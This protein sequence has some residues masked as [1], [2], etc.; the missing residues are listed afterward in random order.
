[1]PDTT[2]TI[3]QD[4]RHTDQSPPAGVAF[5][6][7][8]ERQQGESHDDPYSAIDTANIVFHANLLGPVCDSQYRA[9]RARIL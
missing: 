6:Q 5:E 1:M 2:G 4:E 3:R 7:N 9:V 8:D